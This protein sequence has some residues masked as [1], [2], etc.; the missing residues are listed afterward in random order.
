VRLPTRPPYV[1]ALKD[2]LLDGYGFGGISIDAQRPGVV[3]AASLNQY[4][5][6]AQV[7]YGALGEGEEKC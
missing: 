5:P 1:R 7:R 3:M 6:D 4:Y 2:E